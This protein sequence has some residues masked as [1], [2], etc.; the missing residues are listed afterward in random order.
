MAAIPE[1][2]NVTACNACLNA[3]APDPGGLKIGLPMT[4]DYLNLERKGA[5]EC[6]KYPTATI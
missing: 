2:P 3:I 6:I 5:N 4:V 1:G